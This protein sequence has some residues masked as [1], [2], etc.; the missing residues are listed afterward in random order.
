MERGRGRCQV[1]SRARKR[2]MKA[3]LGLAD[4][5]GDRPMGN[6][7]GPMWN[8]LG[9]GTGGAGRPMWNELG[10]GTGGAGRPMWNE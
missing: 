5:S 10:L 1:G 8:E 6:G 2:G 9:L 3:R 7:D 4:G